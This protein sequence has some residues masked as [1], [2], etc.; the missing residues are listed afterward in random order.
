M[1]LFL[2][3]TDLVPVSVNL[4]DCIMYG[5]DT[6]VLT[7]MYPQTN[8]KLTKYKLVLLR[9]MKSKNQAGPYNLMSSIV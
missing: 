1:A 8:R 3:P 2:L 9:K 7:K 6:M 4:C 5:C